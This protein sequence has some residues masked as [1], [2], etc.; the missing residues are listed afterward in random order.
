MWLG[1]FQD[2]LRAAYE[3]PRNA[4]NLPEL[5]TNW[6]STKMEPGPTRTVYDNLTEE[7]K[8]DWQLLEPA[9]DAAFRNESEEREF[10]TRMDAYQRSKGQSLR[11]YRDELVRR[12]DKYRAALR[13]VQQEWDREAIHRFRVGLKNPLMD[14]QVLLHCQGDAAT[15]EE[16]FALITNW[17]N[18]LSHLEKQG[19]ERGA[20][21]TGP[22]VSTLIGI[23][24]LAPNEPV[25]LGSLQDPTSM[26][27]VKNQMKQHEMKITGLVAGM[28]TMDDKFGGLTEGLSDLSKEVKEGFHLFMSKLE[29]ALPAYPT[30]YPMYRQNSAPRGNIR[31]VAPFR[32]NA[33]M[34]NQRVARGL[35]GGPGYLNNQVRSAPRQPGPVRSIF[36]DRKPQTMAAMGEERSQQDRTFE[37]SNQQS[38]PREDIAQRSQQEDQPQPQMNSVGDPIEAGMFNMGYGWQEGD[39]QQAE[40]MGYDSN[41]NGTYNYSSHPF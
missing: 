31:P 21:S 16:A 14:A 4:P 22:L 36:N 15:L 3:L 30:P 39:T 28:K 26:E 10:M 40:A 17:E 20:I 23:P 25:N 33:N 38:Q 37:D 5:Y 7:V 19:G 34:Y 27:Q 41:P 29:T 6:I 32:G 11:E 9:L 1:H 8:D 2:N 18:T 12:M 35:T 13:Q 24:V